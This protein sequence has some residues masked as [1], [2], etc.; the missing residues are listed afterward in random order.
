M[1]IFSMLETALRAEGWALVR[2]PVDDRYKSLTELLIDD[3]VRRLS[4]PGLDGSCYRTFIADWLYL[5][6]P[7]IDR[8]KGEEFSAQF[9]GPL[10][11]IGDKTYPLGGFILH[12][13][14]WARLSP[15]DAFDLR[16]T[17]RAVVDRSVRKW[18][19]GKDL[20]FVPAL[21]EKPF[22][23]RAAADAEAERQI[24]AFA[25]VPRDLGD[26]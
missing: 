10:V 17:L 14:Q 9:E 21:P 8:F 12:H 6:R 18:M 20:T 5:E 19:E 15:E 1:S 23:D 3:Y 2:V 25:R 13:L 22:P 24:R 11:A 7:M 4:R 26:I 16:E